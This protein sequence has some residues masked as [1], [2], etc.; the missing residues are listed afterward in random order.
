M[1]GRRNV[2]LQ[3]GLVR[4]AGPALGADAR[5]IELATL[6]CLV[7]QVIE[8]RHVPLLGLQG[9]RVAGGG[10][11]F[12]AFRVAFRNAFSSVFRSVLRRAFLD[13]RLGIRL[14]HCHNAW[15]SRM[16]AYAGLLLYRGSTACR[17]QDC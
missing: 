17:G 14:T 5:Q 16:P 11:V 2:A 6:S 12:R 1:L 7:K 3:P 9:G 10:S 15:Y 13:W 4:A 8:H